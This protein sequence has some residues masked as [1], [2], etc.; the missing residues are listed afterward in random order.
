MS[1]YVDGYVL[2]VPKDKLEQYTNM[3]KEAGEY[4]V[5]CGA[6]SYFECVGDDM[7][8]D[9]GGATM[10]QFPDM[11]QAKD[12]E[13]VIFAFVIYNSREHRDEVNQ[14]VFQNMSEKDNDC[15]SIFDWTK[16]AYGG[17][18]SIVMFEQ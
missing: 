6:L 13:V 18:K 2:P 1:K 7:S 5:K 14:K 8:P 11:I 12:D 3:A 9:M 15:D 16:M 10:V 17:F 4:W